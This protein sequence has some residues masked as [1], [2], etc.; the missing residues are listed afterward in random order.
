[1]RLHIPQLKLLLLSLYHYKFFCF[2]SGTVQPILAARFWVPKGQSRFYRQYG[3]IVREAFQESSSPISENRDSRREGYQPIP[4]TTNLAPSASSQALPPLSGPEPS[5]TGTIDIVSNTVNSAGKTSFPTNSTPNQTAITA[6]SGLEANQSDTSTMAPSDIFGTPIA[7]SPPAPYFPVQ[8]DHPRPRTG[9]KGSPPIGTNKFYANFFLANQT[10]PTYVHPYSIVWSKGQGAS[11]SWGLAIS[12]IEAN[13][14]VYGPPSNDTGAAQYFL[15][16]VGIHSL[17]LSAA[18]LGPSTNLTTDNLSAHS[19]NV[20][21]HADAKSKPLITFP[22]VQGMAFVTAVYKGSTPVINTGVYFK[23]VTKSINGPKE[24]MTKYTLYL[25]DSTVWHVYAYSA[26]GDTFDLS[27][28]N[29]KMAK[30]EKPYDGIVQVAKDPGNGAETAID[31]ASGAYP[32]NVTLSGSTSGSKGTYTFTFEKAG[33]S[34]VK[35]LMYA[36]PH[37]VD[38]FDSATHSSKSKAQLQT[39]TKGMAVGVV[40]DSWT[41]VEPNMPV[42]MGFA[43]WHPVD[44]EKKALSDSAINHITKV[45]ANEAGQSVDQQSDQNSMYFGGKALAKFAGISFV[46]KDL[47]KNENLA[48]SG[49][50]N[51]QA[52]FSRFATNKQQFPLY[53][54]SAWGGLVSSATYQTGNEGADFGNTYYNDH[55]FHY[56][57]FIYAAAIIGYLDPSWLTKGNVDYVNTL[58]RDIANPSHLDKHFPVSRN[59]DWYHGHSWAHGLFETADGKDQESSS[60]DAMHAYAIK[61]WGK[62]IKNAN[63][64][65]RGNL[66]LAILARSLNKYYLYTEEND[67]QPPEYVGNRVAGILFENKCDHNTYFGSNIEYIQG[68]HMIPLLPSTRL[69]RS[70]KFVKQEWATYFDNGRADNAEGGWKGILYGNLATVDPKSAWDF[71]TREDFDQMWLDGGASLT[72]YLTYCAA[73]LMISMGHRRRSLDEQWRWLDISRALMAC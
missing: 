56:G 1:M 57:Y 51:L 63:M 39:T 45:A 14:R 19:A 36:L 66:M 58:V 49:L 6:P 22:L 11:S 60:E 24:G 33:F 72:W 16:P 26:K 46:S 43:P 40:A 52:A 28:V 69:T 67:V 47:L 42:S 2:Y 68:I 65:A 59:F 48:Q 25:E 70:A 44:G 12:H 21:L 13:Q 50:K 55:H 5:T 15:N 7:T 73:I 8:K 71:F 29:N 20:N 54:D 32:V 37:H 4:V 23:T 10:Q 35:L 17:C 9:I 64:E 62:T 3:L 53:Y 30:A 38:S 18:E 61:M 41:M 34:N 31:A 27:V